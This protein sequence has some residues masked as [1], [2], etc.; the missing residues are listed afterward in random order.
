M[1]G[2]ATLLTQSRY[3]EASHPVGKSSVKR[4]LSSIFAL[5]L[6]IG[7]VH[8]G[9]IY[10]ELIGAPS[11]AREASLPGPTQSAV[12]QGETETIPEPAAFGFIL[13]G[14][15]AMI[16]IAGGGGRV[17]SVK[18][19]RPAPQTSRIPQGLKLNRGT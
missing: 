8:A 5:V 2:F 7:P 1:F 10:D 4:V 15:V 11:L 6:M 13:L 16:F 12:V 17:N 3:K 14:L 19:S 18:V 9:I